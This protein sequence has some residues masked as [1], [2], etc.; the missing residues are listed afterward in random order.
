MT[1]DT[2][3]LISMTPA[4]G[5]PTKHWLVHECSVVG[6]CLVLAL[7]MAW[8]AAC[9][10]RHLIIQGVANE[11]ANQGNAVEDDLVL[12]REASAFY[13]KLSESLLSES[14]GN[15]KLAEAVSVGFTQYPFAFVAFEAER[16]EAK[17]NPD[18]IADLPLAI[19]LASLAYALK[20]DHGDGA[21]AAQDRPSF[22]ALLRQALAASLTRRDLSNE[23]MRE[24]APWLLEAADDLF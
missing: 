7:V 11:L 15:L 10:P 23:V 19:R 18:T 12:A 2:T 16:I 22:E 13:L 8:L 4:I 6:K 3:A 14:P 20:P 5:K 17:D 21:L 24:R 1:I 9:S